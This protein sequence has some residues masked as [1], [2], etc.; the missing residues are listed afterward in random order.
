M[1][2][3]VLRT[4]SRH[5]L[6]GDP[7]AAD[8]AGDLGDSDDTSVGARDRLVSSRR[9]LCAVSG[10]PDSMAL[11]A[12]LWE[13]APRLKLHLEVATVDHGLRPEAAAEL[14]LVADRAS[15]LSI[16]W[17]PVSV[18]VGAAR[19]PDQGD[20]HPRQRGGVQE[21]ARRLRLAALAELADRRELGRV[22]LGHNAD[23][24]SETVLFRVL[25]GTGPR[26]LAGI[27]YRRGPFIRPLLDVTRAEIL[28]YL[29]R[30]SLPYA[31]DPSNSDVRYTRARL[32]HRI[33]PL[34]RQENPR[35]DVALRT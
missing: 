29:D 30:R 15:A 11:L 3:H 27:P 19:A 12:C 22:A 34:L 25:R 14:Q 8:L 4:I 21:V 18:D 5:K 10:G 13:L 28:A 2:S 31:I 23:D 32:R 1:L 24:Q 9:V 16:P 35:V 17:H 26:G 33:L 6:L 7:Y 20:G